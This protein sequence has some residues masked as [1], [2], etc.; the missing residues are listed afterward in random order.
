MLGWGS[1]CSVRDADNGPDYYKAYL[2][3]PLEPG[4]V[5]L[6]RRRFWWA[7]Q[8]QSYAGRFF[9]RYLRLL[10]AAGKYGRVQGRGEREV[11]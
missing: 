10:T 9:D 5:K 1:Y 2:W 8:A 6:S 3:S 11:E 7:S 4:I